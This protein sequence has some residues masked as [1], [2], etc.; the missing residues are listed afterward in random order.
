MA[1][2]DDAQAARRRSEF[3]QAL[4]TEHFAL[5]GARS[6]TISESAARSSLYM[7]SLSSS[8][9]ALALVGQVSKLGE[10]FHIFALVILRKPAVQA[11]F[12]RA[13]NPGGPPMERGPNPGPPPE[14]PQTRQPILAKFRA[15]MQSVRNYCVDSLQGDRPSP[16]RNDQ[17]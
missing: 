6:G 11:A 1:E 2:A 10:A 17:E 4:T 7:T 8:V 9:V 15:M 14:P 16:T 13:A 3:L 12:A 5:Q